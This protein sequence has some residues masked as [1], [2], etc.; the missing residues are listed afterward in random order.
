MKKLTFNGKQRGNITTK[1]LV[2]GNEKPT[3]V[4]GHIN[5]TILTIEKN[6]VVI[7]DIISTGTV[8][9]KGSVKGNIKAAG[10]V[11]LKENAVLLGNIE[12]V[13][14]DLDKT[15]VL[16]GFCSQKA[17]RIDLDKIFS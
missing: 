15:S 14:I 11:S 6:A 3:R 7:G 10:S 2:L 12:A 16:K 9:V 8:V 17:D 5:G 1:D 13:A 4:E